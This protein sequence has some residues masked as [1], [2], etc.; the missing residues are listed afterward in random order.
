[1]LS[2]YFCNKF[3]ISINKAGP[4]IHK[5]TPIPICTPIA[6]FNENNESVYRSSE[7]GNVYPLGAFATQAV[8][9]LVGVD[10]VM[11]F[12]QDLGSSSDKE[13]AYKKNFK[14][15]SSKLVTVLQGYIDSIRSKKEWSLPTLE[16]KYKEAI[17]KG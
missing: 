6:F 17:G 9:A 3:V 11:S 7:W 5:N 12:Y 2:K 4:R 8:V 14:L 16:T 13:S 15:E 10:A 1:V